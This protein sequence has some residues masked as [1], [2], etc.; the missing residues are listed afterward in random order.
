M[1]KFVVFRLLKAM[2]GSR[3]ADSQREAGVAACSPVV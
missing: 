2:G 1:I 3:C